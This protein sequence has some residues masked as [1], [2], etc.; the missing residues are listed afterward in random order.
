MDETRRNRWRS[1][2]K[3]YSIPFCAHRRKLRIGKIDGSQLTQSQIDQAQSA[4]AP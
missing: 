3:H 4:E 2:A 1:G